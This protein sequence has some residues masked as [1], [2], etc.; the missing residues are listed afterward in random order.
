MDI[1]AA[2]EDVLVLVEVKYRKD[3]TFSPAE[4]ALT[5]AKRRKLLKAGRAAA[6]RFGKN[7]N[8]RFDFVALI[9]SQDRPEIR[10]YANVIEG[11]D[12]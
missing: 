3:E 6:Q 5:S 1:V 10:Y 2:E 4:E 7:S 9:G 8:V 11:F 12:L